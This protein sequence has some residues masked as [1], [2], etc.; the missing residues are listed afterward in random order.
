MRKPDERIFNFLIQDNLIK[1]EE[2]VFI[3]DYD[4][5]ISAANSVGLR[6]LWLKPGQD[7]FDIFTQDGYLI[8]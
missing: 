7:L 1:A 6:G 3:D 5:N 8:D 2:T 4:I